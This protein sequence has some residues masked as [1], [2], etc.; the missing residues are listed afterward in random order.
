MAKL[1]NLG[2]IAGKYQQKLLA[3][4]DSFKQNEFDLIL[5]EFREVY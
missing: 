2:T 1:M 3:L 5:D 4:R